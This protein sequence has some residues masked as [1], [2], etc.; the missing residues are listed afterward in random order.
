MV[1]ERE[2]IVEVEVALVSLAHVG[3]P[4]GCEKPDGQFVPQ[5]AMVVNA[6]QLP[7]SV[8][9]PSQSLSL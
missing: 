3:Q 4:V 1:T 6:D 2:A 8:R 9:R 5:P 7:S